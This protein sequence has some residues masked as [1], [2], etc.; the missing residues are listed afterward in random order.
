MVRMWNMASF[1]N[2]K[3]MTGGAYRSAKTLEEYDCG[4]S[5]Y[6]TLQRL[7]YSGKEGEG[8]VV[9]NN[10]DSG[11]WVYVTPGTV[12]ELLFRLACKGG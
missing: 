6:R 2:M 3:K 4:N 9:Y 10:T 5:K 8:Q 12:D 1:A 11:D 7:A